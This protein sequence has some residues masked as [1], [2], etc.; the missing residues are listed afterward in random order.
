[1]SKVTFRRRHLVS[2][3]KWQ[4]YEIKFGI[5]HSYLVPLAGDKWQWRHYD[6]D[7]LESKTFNSIDEADAFMIER[8]SVIEKCNVI[9]EYIGDGKICKRND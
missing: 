2:N 5:I 8:Y 1:M 9:I 7:W 4:C 3:P 6:G